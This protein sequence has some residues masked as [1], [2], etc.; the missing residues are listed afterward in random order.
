[1]E[2][3]FRDIKLPSSLLSRQYYDYIMKRLNQGVE[4]FTKKYLAQGIE[5]DY[6]GLLCL[7]SIAKDPSQEVIIDAADK[8][9]DFIINGGK[10][11]D[12]LNE[13]YFI[14]VFHALKHAQDHN[15]LLKILK[16]IRYYIRYESPLQK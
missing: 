10:E 9:F 2:Q 14:Y 1:M 15:I 11:K 7:L 4:N 6:A 16:V 8:L 5:Q 13:T 12:P 3:I